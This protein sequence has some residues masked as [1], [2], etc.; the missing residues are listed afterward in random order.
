MEGRNFVNEA[1]VPPE[2]GSPASPMNRPILSMR[3]FQSMQ[4]YADRPLACLRGDESSVVARSRS[5]GFLDPQ[6]WHSVRL[7]TA[8]S[9]QPVDPFDGFIGA[10][11]GAP[12]E[13]FVCPSIRCATFLVLQIPLALAQ[14]SA[15]PTKR[16]SFPQTFWFDKI[17][18][19]FAEKSQLKKESFPGK[20][21]LWHHKE[22]VFYLG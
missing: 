6:E 20:L 7:L 17:I 10:L 19:K 11:K 2:C 13:R 15:S 8:L 3:R 21:F 16:A 14:A 1:C 4:G 5:S 22:P 12:N 9:L 18:L